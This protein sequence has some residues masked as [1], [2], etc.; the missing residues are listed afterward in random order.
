MAGKNIPEAL[1]AY[2]REEG[3]RRHYRLVD[4]GVRGRHALS[5]EIVLDKEGGIK[6]DECGDFNRNI[7]SWIE[8]HG[9]FE[10]GCTVEVCSPGLDRELKS[11]DDFSWAQGRSVCVTT[12]EPVGARSRII[13]K[14]LRPEGEV[15]ISIEDTGGNIFRIK[16]DMIANARLYVDARK[17]L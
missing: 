3:D 16:R 13:G 1:A 4:I 14:L 11:D 7:T 15:D 12:H 17:T 9:M 8:Q 2:I 5:L 6:M 10:G